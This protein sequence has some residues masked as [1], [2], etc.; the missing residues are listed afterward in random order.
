MLSQD[1]GTVIRIPS[2]ANLMIDSVDRPAT[3][4]S[5]WEFQITRYNNL[6][7]GYFNRIGTTEIVLEWCEPNISGS[8]A[9]RTITVDISGVAANAYNGSQA[10]LFPISF[11]TVE[12]LLNYLETALNAVSGTTGADFNI[13]Q[14]GGL[15]VIDCSGAV[16]Q[17]QDSPLAERADLPILNGLEDKQFVGNCPDLRLYRY[18]DFT[19]EQLTYAQDVKDAATNQANRN[20]LARWYMVYDNPVG[21]DGYG[22]PIL[23]GYKQFQLRRIF[24]PPKQIKWDNNL[25]VGNLAFQVYNDQGD[26]MSAVAPD[27]KSNWLMTLQLSEN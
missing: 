10:V 1:K 27:N 21:E 9:N 2:T 6:Q 8:Q 13:T 23:M 4:P 25:P 15:T 3:N 14:V 17:F 26:L 16:F 7:V 24:S 22:F 11:S 12:D 18:L 19:S 5:P 20:V